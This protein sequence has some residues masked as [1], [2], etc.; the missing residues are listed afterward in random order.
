MQSHN[1]RDKTTNGNSNPINN[2]GPLQDHPES[3]STAS[4]RKDAAVSALPAL[5]LAARS[6][7][8][9]VL[10]SPRGTPNS[11][12]GLTGEFDFN[13]PASSP[14]DFQ[15]PEMDE[16]PLSLRNTNSHNSNSNSTLNRTNSNNDN[17]Q[18]QHSTGSSTPKVEIQSFTDRATKLTTSPKPILGK[19]DGIEPHTR[20]AS[21]SLTTPKPPPTSAVAQ[22]IPS[23]SGNLQ[24]IKST[25]SNSGNP[26][27][28]PSF[29]T[30]FSNPFY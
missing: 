29:P 16:G 12:P 9:P 15:I 18:S 3:P 11:S 22:R 26:P 30:W 20:K 28:H 24:R 8:T 27:I 17:S 1:E 13:K 14:L 2:T 21:F 23:S 7:G 10:L 5:K 6:I 25:G 19:K 4:Q